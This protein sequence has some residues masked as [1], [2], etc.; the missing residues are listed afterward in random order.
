MDDECVRTLDGG[1]ACS[2]TLLIDASAPGAATSGVF[3]DGSDAGANYGSD[4]RC[5]F[6]IKAGAGQS[7]WP[8]QLAHSA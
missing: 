1:G 5:N 2:G 3:T 6:L 8:I 7:R 4:R